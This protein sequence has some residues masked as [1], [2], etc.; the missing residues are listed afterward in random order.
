[1]KDE[2]LTKS[3]IPNTLTA[4]NMF[5]GFAAII[6]AGNG[7]FDTAVFLI[8]AAA[9]FD[10]LDGFMARIV[11]T[12]SDFGVQLDSLSDVV[13]FG[14]A[15]AYL[16]YK[17]YLYLYG[18]SGIVVSSLL[19]LFGAFRL[20]KFN[21]EADPLAPKGMFKGLPIPLS[22]LTAV[23]FI[24][25]INEGGHLQEPYAYFIIPLIAVLSFLMVSGVE[26]RPL[27]IISE[28]EKKR[29]VLLLVLLIPA[30]F[31]LYASNGKLLFFIFFSIVIFGILK[32]MFID[33][34]SGEKPNIVNN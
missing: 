8:I 15:P 26:Y 19:V 9:I 10:T 34:G 25:N 22:G 18:Y 29:K 2:F 16:V 4:L 17:S 28:F 30:L 5:S 21:V 1:M 3:A 7:Q 13:S 23:T 31:V 12:S 27:S 14:A 24:Y 32:N 20:A 6:S 11:R 33:P